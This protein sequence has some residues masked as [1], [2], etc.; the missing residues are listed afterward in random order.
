MNMKRTNKKNQKELK[1]ERRLALVRTTIRDLSPNQLG[2]VN[3]GS[4]IDCLPNLTRITWTED[5]IV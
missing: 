5:N 3:G 1:L 4:G 2:Q